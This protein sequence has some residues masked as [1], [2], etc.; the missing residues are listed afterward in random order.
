M[1][2]SAVLVLSVRVHD[3]H[4]RGQGFAAQVVV[5]DHNVSGF[6]GG[7]RLVREGAAIDA[8][9]QIVPRGQIGHG[10]RVRSVTFVDAVGDVERGVAAQLAEPVQ[11]E[12]GRGAAIDVVIRKDR[13]LLPLE[14]RLDQ[15]GGGGFHVAE[16]ARI[17]QEIA[18]LWVEI[19]F[20]LAGFDTARSQDAADG[21][22][23]GGLLFQRF[24]L[25][26]QLVR[27]AGPAPPQDRGFDIEKGWLG[28]IF[29]QGICLYC[30]GS[31]RASTI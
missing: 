29:G 6:G 17:G 21:L 20:G 10:G 2:E 9:D 22:G 25:A 14:C 11:E 16:G 26:D 8:N 18:K 12:R 3:C 15:S 5:E 1:G 24:R 23:Q 4:G 7:D 30:G 27:W 28:R 13:H 31:G 19:G